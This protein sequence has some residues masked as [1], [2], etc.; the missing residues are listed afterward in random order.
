MNDPAISDDGERIS[1]SMAELAALLG[2][3]TE[4]IIGVDDSIRITFASPGVRQL[5]GY[6]PRSLVG[7]DL[8]QYLH[9]DE[10]DELLSNLARWEGRAGQPAG[11]IQRVLAI[12]GSW[13]KIHYDTVFG[14]TIAPFGSMVLTVRAAE[15]LVPTWQ[16]QRQRELNEDRLVRLAS[17]FLH[18]PVEEFDLGLQKTV[19]ELAGLD[20]VTRVSVWRIDGSRAVRRAQWVA[21]V[22]APALEL[23]DR[24]RVDDWPAVARM[25]E[26][27][28]IHVHSPRQVADEPNDSR[29]LEES[30]VR[31][32]VAVP[33]AA[34]GEFSG[35]IMIEATGADAVFGA[36]HV[37]AVRSAAAILAE[38][39]VR[40]GTELRLAEQLR[41]DHVT[42]LGTRWAFDE[43]LTATLDAVAR[44]A[45]PGFALAL[46]D[47]DRFSLVNDA[48][49][50]AAGD[51]LLAD[52]A[53]RL[54][55]VAGPRTTLARLGSDQILVLHDGEET[56]TGAIARTQDL[57]DGLRTPFE[58]AGRPVTLT[59]SVGLVHALDASADAVELIRRADLALGRAKDHGGDTIE[60]DDEHLRARVASR[61]HRETELRDAVAGDGIEVHYQGEWDLVTG[62]L[63]AAEALARWLHPSEGL[64]D[65]GAF[66]PLAEES[67]VIDDLGQRV[68]REA[69]AALGSWRDQGLA[70]DLVMRVNV[71]A[72]QLRNDDLA[73]QVS[74]ALADSGIP[75]AALCLELTESALLIDPAGSLA[76]LERLRELGVGLAVDDFGT[77]YSSLL[78]LKRLPVTAVKIDR[79]FVKDLPEPISDR[80]I[81]KAVVQ[82]AEAL[83]ITCT[84]EGVETVEQRDALVALGCHRAQGFLLARP[85][86]TDE[87]AERL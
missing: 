1:V 2:H 63:V 58:V 84:A 27:H 18:H 42:G 61:L 46:L 22:H 36:T 55:G 78:Y 67:R 29:R 68:L 15:D 47:L 83:D 82:L 70:Q 14:P 37:T 56:L 12:D 77:G 25:A 11:Q 30:G 64:L 71:S 60:V 81:V 80:A 38:A 51:L 9:P 40:H 54:A 8:L 41:T 79:A 31:S 85:E 73:E 62:K 23:F 16:D 21:P 6:D 4:A 53:A 7:Q 26:G 43:T 19:E 59:A 52:V 74:D 65:A 20:W 17:T 49:G 32:L 87:F 69:C 34:N 45:S 28:E 10:V 57:L 48:L 13:R 5:F 75:A 86:S 3:T 50:H 76:R 33:M 72:R 39:F 44:H 66:I 24:I 35:F